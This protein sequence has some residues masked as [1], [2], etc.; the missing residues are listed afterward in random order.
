MKFKKYHKIGQFKDVVRTVHFKANFVGLDEE[1][2]PQYEEKIKPVIEFRGTVK[3]H[4]TNAGICFNPEEGMFAQKRSSLL[5]KEQ[6]DSHFG[7]NQFVQVTQKEKLEQLMSNLY[8]QYCQEGDQ[9]IIYGEWAGSNIQKGVA[10]SELPKS[11]YIFDCKVYTPSTDSSK[12]IDIKDLQFNIPNVYN[13]NDFTTYT[14]TINFNNPGLIQ[15]SLIEETIKVEEECPISKHLGVS[16]IGEGIVWSAIWEEEKLIFKVKGEKHSTS[17]VKTLAS[18]DP[19]V[20]KN[21]MEFVEYAC[22]PNRIEQGIQEVGATEKKDMP[23]LLKW[24]ANDIIAEETQELVANNLE[25]K[26]VARECSNRVRQYFFEKLD[27]I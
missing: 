12:W 13:I 21:V 26:Q 24:V 18:V 5:S 25:W 16:G 19:E 17:K 23:N 2:N 6:L 11:F 1:G 7:F 9:V 14:I 22:T 20:L 15:N 10:I 27:K 3:L 4:G 8:N